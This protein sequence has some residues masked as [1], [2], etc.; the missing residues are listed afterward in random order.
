MRQHPLQAEAQELVIRAIGLTRAGEDHPAIQALNAAL[1]QV[2][3]KLAGALNGDYERETGYVL[4]MLKRCL[5][6][7][8]DAL[9]ACT[10]L[11]RA[12]EDEDQ[13]RALE[14]LKETIFSIREEIVNLRKKLKEN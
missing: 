3:G 6:W 1:M 4:A 9:A 7:Q 12:A 11:V 13:R 14:A 8:N 2:A 10:E 5:G